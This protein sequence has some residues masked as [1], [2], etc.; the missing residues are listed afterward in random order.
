MFNLAGVKGL[1]LHANGFTQVG[2]L[3]TKSVLH[4]FPLQGSD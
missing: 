2:F 3:D 4:H 1:R